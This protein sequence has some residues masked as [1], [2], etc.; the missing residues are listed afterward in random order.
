MV[1]RLVLLQQT[2]QAAELSPPNEPVAQEGS[3][4]AAA[5]SEAEE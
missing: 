4:G 1:L 5:A 2:S 3:Q